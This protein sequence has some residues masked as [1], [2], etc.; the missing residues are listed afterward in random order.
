MTVRLAISGSAGTGKSS[1][2]MGL[3][4]SLKLPYIEE[5]FRRQ[6]ENGLVFQNLSHAEQSLLIIDLYT[7]AI[8][9]ALSLIHI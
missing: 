9:Q 6:R 8:E 2:A 4:N 5:S 1:L 7:E 3:A